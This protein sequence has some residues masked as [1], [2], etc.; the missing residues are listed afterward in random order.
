MRSRQLVGCIIVWHSFLGHWRSIIMGVIMRVQSSG[1]T[2]DACLE[3]LMGLV[4]VFG[5]RI[6]M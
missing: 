5:A 2:G 3:A 4:V 6:H 1:M